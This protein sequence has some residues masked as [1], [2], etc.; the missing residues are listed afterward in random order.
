MIENTNTLEV[1]NVVAR[2][3]AIRFRLPLN[4]NVKD[5]Q[6]WA[7]IG[8]NGG[9]KT[10]FVDTI[11]GRYGLKSGVVT[12]NGSHE[13]NSFVKCVSFRDIYTLGDIKNSYYQQRWNVG[14]EY[15]TPSVSELLAKGD[16]KWVEYLV[17]MLDIADLYLKP[18]NLLS[19]GELRK[20]LIVRSLLDKPRILVVDNPFIGLDEKSRKLLNKVL[21]LLATLENLQIILIL[22]NPKDIPDTITHILPIKDKTLLPEMDRDKFTSDI[23]FQN[24]L[25]FSNSISSIPVLKREDP[26]ITFQYALIF[27]NVH[28]RYGERTILKNLNWE[29]QK[30][31]K[32]VLLG[33]NGSGKSTLLSL[34]AGDNPQAYAND[35]TLFDRKRGTG[36]S[37]WDIKKNIG[38]VS[39]EIHLYYLKNVKCKEV[40]GSGFFDTIGLYRKCSEE[41]EL[42]ALE[43]MKAFGVEAI[44]DQSFLNISTGEQRLILLA[45]AFVKD[46][47]LLILD[48]PLHGLDV[49]NKARVKQ[50]IE[51]YCTSEKALIYVTHYEEEIPRIVTK[52]LVLTKRI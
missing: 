6:Y 37:I 31:E 5:G 24:E 33:E 3:D 26:E 45:R 50:I 52:R 10:L 22:S 28:V 14:N 47:S 23:D 38:Y 8:P 40:V 43:W 49:T 17:G 15:D 44:K 48:E 46:P 30:G 4:W 20:V 11:L 19:S 25:F 35:I 12:C 51:D 1:R 16:V 9:G 29:V 34:V 41:Q 21:G 18:M 39:P 2:L 27:K 13:L 36:E 7:I 42:Q 32:W